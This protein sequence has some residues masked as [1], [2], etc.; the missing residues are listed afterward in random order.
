MLHLLLA[1]AVAVVV[2][3]LGYMLFFYVLQALGCLLLEMC[4]L[5]YAFDATS[6][7]SLFYKIV[8]VDHAVSL[9]L[10]TLGKENGTVESPATMLIKE[11][12]F[13]CYGNAEHIFSV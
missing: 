2:E 12:S 6:L 8:K 5:H 1:K 7:I 3:C 10:L 4:V 9:L 13:P 11:K